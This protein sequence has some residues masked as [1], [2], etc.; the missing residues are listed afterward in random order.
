[1]K[2]NPFKKQLAAAA[3]ASLTLLWLTGCGGGGAEDPTSVALKPKKEAPQGGNA[4]G[5]A[6][7]QNAATPAGGGGEPAKEGFGTIKGRLVIAEAD[8][9]SLPP[10]DLK[11]YGVGQA[12]VD[13]SFCA[14]DAPI[15]N[16]SLIV[17]RENMGLKNAFFF[18]ERKPRGGKDKA[19]SQSLWPTAD[20]SGQELVLDQHNCT[21]IPHA[22]IVSAGQPFLVQSQDGVTHSYKYSGLQNGSDNLT[23]P[24]GG[25]ASAIQMTFRQPEANPV[26]VSCATHNWMSAYQ[27]PLDHPYGAVTNDNGEF[28]ISDLPSGKHTFTIWHEERGKV[29]EYPVTVKADETVDLGEITLRL[30][31]LSK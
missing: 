24:S 19:E 26:S 6:G 12:K 30:S 22:M 18:L 29:R 3:V 14:K 21:Y 16:E 1:M 27:L 5:N 2:S 20:D 7:G 8:K 9:G 31:Q 4:G 13:P 23:V 11:I 25:R 10:A 28:T 17:N 15:V